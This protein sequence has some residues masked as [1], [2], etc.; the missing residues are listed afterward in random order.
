MD[1]NT[2][3][4]GYPKP[5]KAIDASTNNKSIEYIIEACRIHYNLPP[6][7]VEKQTPNI[8]VALDSHK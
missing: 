2:N 1:P 7:E 5:K 8:V 4:R 6:Y 3:T